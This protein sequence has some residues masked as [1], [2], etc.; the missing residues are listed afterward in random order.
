MRVPPRRIDWQKRTRCSRRCSSPGK[1]K[2]TKYTCPYLV[3]VFVFSSSLQ[4]RE[5]VD[6][7]GTTFDGRQK[8]VD[9]LKKE[10][11]TSKDA[12]ADSQARLDKLERARKTNSAAT[13]ESDSYADA[14]VGAEMQ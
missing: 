6:R 1:L 5:R 4:L 12:L 11:A 7:T 10:L 9:G 3:E 8:E 14:L 13:L 2:S